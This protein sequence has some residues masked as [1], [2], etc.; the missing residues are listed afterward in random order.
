MLLT[1]HP[2]VPALAESLPPS[3][4]GLLERIGARAAV[5]AAG[6]VRATGNT[7][8]WGADETRPEAF[9]PGA[10]GFQVDRGVFDRCL[11]DGAAAA[12]AIVRTGTSVVDVERVS[13]GSDGAR[14]RYDSGGALDVVRA[15]WVLDCSGRTG[16]LA[17]QGW[18]LAQPG[19]RTLALIGVWDAPSGFDLQDPTH[20]LV[21]SYEGGWAWSVPVALTRRF[22]TVMVDPALTRVTGSGDL[23][24]IY[25]A[26]LARTTHLR[27]LVE[28]ARLTGAPFARDASPYTCSHAGEVG[29]L[30]IGDAASF[31]DPLSSYGVKKA[32]ASAWLASVVVHTSLADATMA[33]PALELYNTREAAMYETLSRRSAALAGDAASAH[34]TPFWNARAVSDT[35]ESDADADIDELRRDIEVLVAFGEIRRRPSIALRRNDAIGEVLRPT[36]RENRVVLEPHLMVPALGGGVRYLR[37]VDLLT[38]AN[39]APAHEQV[40]DLFDAY[41]RAAVPAALPDF[42]GALAVLVGKGVLTLAES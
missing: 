6:F 18:R 24:V 10:L 11:L 26:E 19:S 9:G 37:N 7:V 20:T 38:L 33:T 15:R 36:V 42:L 25:E 31:V 30:L 28:T 34:A 40:P 39:L 16:L 22:F 14:I 32:L 23:A 5:E 1:R 12:G 41:N 13:D 4:L 35:R 3:C 2:P 8:W 21:E 17:R 27:R 29:V